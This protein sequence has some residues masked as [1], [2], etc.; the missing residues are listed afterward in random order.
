MGFC[1]IGSAP[2][3]TATDKITVVSEMYFIVVIWERPIGGLMMFLLKPVL[4]IFNFI[5]LPSDIVSWQST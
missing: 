2:T 4:L 5:P 3:I 1:E